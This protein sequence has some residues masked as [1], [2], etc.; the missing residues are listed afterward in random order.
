MIREDMDDMRVQAVISLQQ[1]SS[2][3]LHICC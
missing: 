3:C 1:R 2:Y